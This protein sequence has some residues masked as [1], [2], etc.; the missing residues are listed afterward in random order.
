MPVVVQKIVASAQITPIR[1]AARF[2]QP[3]P[4]MPVARNR[5]VETAAAPEYS[6]HRED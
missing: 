4:D 1:V 3:M 2:T 5:T 6:I